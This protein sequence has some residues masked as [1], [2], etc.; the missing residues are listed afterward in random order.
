MCL[1]IRPPWSFKMRQ[2]PTNGMEQMQ[3]M[4]FKV[5]A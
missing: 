2:I 1:A 4:T 3:A 5:L